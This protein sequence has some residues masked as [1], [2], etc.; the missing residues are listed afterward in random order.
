MK[1]EAM[2]PKKHFRKPRQLRAY[3]TMM[4]Y[5]FL[6]QT[7]NP[8]TF[9]FGFIFPVVFISIFGLI[10]GGPQKLTLGIPNDTNQNNPIV[11]AV[12]K[13]GFI[14]VK[15]D[16]RPLLENQLKQGK[17]A[18]IISVSQTN[19]NNKFT[20]NEVTSTGNLTEG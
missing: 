10:G 19:G 4:K 6:A 20:V 13:Q 15:K 2:Q 8:A 9:A 16:S 1:E 11:T 7:R 3:F 5:F 17:I 14:T 12:E 18:G